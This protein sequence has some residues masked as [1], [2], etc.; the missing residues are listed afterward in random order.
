MKLLSSRCK[1]LL[2]LLLFMLATAITAMAT[3]I[4]VSSFSISNSRGYTGTVKL[5]IYY[6]GCAGSNFIDSTG[7]VIMCGN[8]GSST[9]FY[10]EIPVTVAGGTLTIPAHVL[11]ST[12]DSSTLSVTATA[13]FFVN[14]AKRD[15]L[16]SNW[17]ITRTLGTTVSFAQ[18]WDFNE[19]VV[20]PNPPATFLSAADTSALIRDSSQAPITEIPSGSIN[21]SNQTF[22]ISQALVLDSE[23]V[24]LNGIHQRRVTSACALGTETY[25]ISGQTITHCLPPQTGDSLIVSYRI[26]APLIGTIDPATRIRET[27]GPTTLSVGVV[28]DGACLRRLGMSVEGTACGGGGGGGLQDPGSNG[29]VK[30]TALNVTVAA[31]PGT[32]YLLPTGS[33]A[34]LTALNASELASGTMPDARFP[35]TL[36]AVSGVNLISLNASNIASGTLADARLSANIPRLNAVNTFVANNFF[37]ADVGIGTLTPRRPLDV[38]SFSESQLRLTHTDNTAYTD[39]TVSS[40]GI[41][42]IAPTGSVNF[43]AA[44]NQIDPATNFDQNLG[45]ISKKYLSL[46]AAELFVETLVAQDTI[47]TIGG[48]ILV[49]PTTQLV[50][51]LTAVATTI[52]VKHNQM[53]SGD[54]V[55]LEG[56]GVVEFMAITSPPSVLF[57]GYRYTVTRN[58]D[59][60][61]A[62][63]WFAGDAVFNTGQ[64][65]D[66]FI[67]L[68]SVSGVKSGTELGPTIVGNIRNSATFNDWSPRWAIGNLSGLYGYGSTTYGV[69]LGV[70]NAAWIKIDPTNGVRIG[71]NLATLAQIDASGNASFTG[72]I[73]A[74][75]GAVA[76]WTIN[77]TNLS[78]GTTHLASSFAIPVTQHSWFG[79]GTPGY[80]GWSVQDTTGRQIQALVN[81]GSIFPYLSFHDSVRFRVVIGGLNNAWGSD[82]S[83]NSMGMKVWNSAGTKLLEFSDV[84]NILSGWTI[85]SASISSTGINI[86]SGASAGMAFGTTPPTSASAGTGIWLDRTGLYGLLSNVVQAKF[87]AATGALTGGAGNVVLDANGLKL[88]EGSSSIN[89]IRWVDGSGNTVVQMFGNV[90][91]S[92]TST[93]TGFNL[94]SQSLAAHTAGS[95]QVFLSAENDGALR[96]SITLNKFGSTHASANIGQID[97]EA[98]E[99]RVFG[100][101]TVTTTVGAFLPP[102]MT[103]TQRDAL[104]P[105][106]GMIIYNTTTGT[107]NFRKAGVWTAL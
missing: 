19:D 15:F 76:G 81:N 37:T 91:G 58:L 90:T 86:N 56:N 60:T 48:R 32:D 6:T 96:S 4:T 78:S 85:G 92:G 27:G 39:F 35:A 107:L 89:F 87:D 84:Q 24:T 40:G 74:A 28:A 51:D 26:R 21:S 7:A 62:D 50:A 20:L 49:G 52:D 54:R 98:T 64:V 13:L 38:A 16:Y 101:L 73:T 106:D 47:G 23:V 61:G 63:P 65:G 95:S 99:T 53:I 10:A 57:N 77:A 94:Q 59:G 12:D 93:A 36:P 29:L 102:R 67:D 43:D 82:G 100:G 83:T 2:L 104:T 14:N 66:G 70:P 41:I 55:Y 97:I 105:I 9:G 71:H 42:T 8:V 25:S 34:G 75:A 3:D 30:R 46:H 72:T 79:K 5:R 1:R 80:Q 69:A 45:Q 68:Y 31:T 17:V 33:G 103:T 44:G 88:V 22:T 11:P 18:L